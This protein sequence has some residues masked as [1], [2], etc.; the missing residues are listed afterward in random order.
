MNPADAAEEAPG[1][2]DTDA[3]YKTGRARRR[4]RKPRARASARGAVGSGRNVQGRSANG[5]G[6]PGWGTR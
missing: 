4:A 2:P 1:D 3:F 6:S 5:G